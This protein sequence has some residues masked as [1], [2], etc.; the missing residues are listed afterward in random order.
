[1]I[2]KFLSEI[3]EKF[4]EKFGNFSD[5]FRLFLLLWVEVDRSFIDLP[6]MDIVKLLGFLHNSPVCW[7]ASMVTYRK[8]NFF[9]AISLADA[10]AG[11][12]VSV[13]GITF[14]RR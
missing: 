8:D 4:S 6:V 1:M 13:R 9:L 2:Y 7:G 10:R 5:F 3:L 11:F 12:P 14:T